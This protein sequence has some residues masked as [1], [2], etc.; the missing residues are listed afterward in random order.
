MVR[1]SV[2]L[3]AESFETCSKR[4]EVFVH[5]NIYAA[6]IPTKILVQIVNYLLGLRF[7][8]LPSPIWNRTRIFQFAKILINVNGGDSGLLFG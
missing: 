3:Q 8:N 1:S 6:K 5:T 7:T 2:S 4:S